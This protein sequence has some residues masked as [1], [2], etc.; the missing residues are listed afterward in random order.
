[1]AK[2][3]KQ[4]LFRYVFMM[5]ATKTLYAVDLLCLHNNNMNTYHN[6]VAQSQ[7]GSV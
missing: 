3:N 7:H 2:K 4:I 5:R 1:M 6:D